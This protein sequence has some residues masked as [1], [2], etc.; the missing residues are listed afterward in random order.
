MPFKYALEM[1]CDFLG[2]GHA[3]WRKNF[4]IQ[5]ESD[6]WREKR[7]VAKLHIE[8]RNLIDLMMNTMAVSNHY[9]IL[10]DRKNLKKIEQWYNS[11][12]LVDLDLYNPD[13][14]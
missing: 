5:A 4:T 6:L 3:Y 7:K 2:A 9:G 13:Y 8:T 1:F 14:M 11:G 12:R 10:K